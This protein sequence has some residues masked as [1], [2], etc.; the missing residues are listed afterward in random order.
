M[1]ISLYDFSIEKLF[2]LKIDMLTYS[3]SGNSHKLFT[4]LSPVVLLAEKATFGSVVH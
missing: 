2:Y 4:L 1:L 3:T